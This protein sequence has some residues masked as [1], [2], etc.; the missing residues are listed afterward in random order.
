MQR[1]LH[2]G[3]EAPGLDTVYDF[4]HTD[5]GFKYF[6]NQKVTAGFM[7]MHH[8]AWCLNGLRSGK[9]YSN[10]TARELLRRLGYAG[11]TLV[12]SPEN[13]MNEAW[14]DSWKKVNPDLNIYVSDGS[15]RELQDH[16]KPHLDVCVVNHGKLPYC[17]IDLDAWDFDFLIIDEG[18][19]YRTEGKEP[20][21][22]LR[23]LTRNRPVGPYASTRPQQRWVWNLTGTPYPNSATDVYPM[24]RIINPS[25]MP[26]SFS[27]WRKEVQTCHIVKDRFGKFVF[28]DWRDKDKKFVAE[29]C[30]SVMKPS[31]RFRTED[32]VDLPD[33]AYS[34]FH[35]PVEGDQKILYNM[36]GR[37]K[38][39]KMDGDKFRVRN[40]PNKVNKLFQVASGTVKNTDNEW[41]HI[42]AK[43]RMDTL[44]DLYAKADGKIVVFVNFVETA[45]YI[46]KELRKH[47]IKCDVINSTVSRKRR[48]K[49]RED[50]Q[51]SERRSVLV[52]HP[53]TTRF[54]TNVSAASVTIWWVPP[55]QGEYWIQGNERARAPGSTKT[56]IAMFY[57]G[58]TERGYYERVRDKGTQNNRTVDM[59]AEFRKTRA[60]KAGF[61]KQF[62]AD[63]SEEC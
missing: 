1:L 52:M 12:L 49:I 42:G 56:L 31:I 39:G 35:T 34:Y 47:K 7:A 30:A 32:C 3:I 38:A 50:F 2:L 20:V 21:N 37:H 54:G 8:R 28:P 57:S 10:I 62:L 46:R 5:P 18:S 41:V 4:P 29:R 59:D 14:G 61:E 45:E 15:V 24:T 40:A 6:D 23:F 53:E 58:A 26:I 48:E 25:M 43:K 11:R 19:I 55:F 60:T 36:V 22:N 63:W 51:K 13:V 16:L 44:L 33:Q 17:V 9:T 27:Q